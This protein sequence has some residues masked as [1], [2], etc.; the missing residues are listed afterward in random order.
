MSARTWCLVR[1]ERTAKSDTPMQDESACS[2]L[3]VA[4]LMPHQL[5]AALAAAA[6]LLLTPQVGAEQWRPLPG[7]SWQW[8]LRDYAA[9]PP[10]LSGDVQL[11]DLYALDTAA[12]AV[13]GLHAHG[14]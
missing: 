3:I 1:R 4:P 6:F 7:M 12:S 5:A 13:G 11:Y 14:D 10:D 2:L 8:Q 9:G